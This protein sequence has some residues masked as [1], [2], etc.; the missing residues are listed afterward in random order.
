MDIIA[1]VNSD[2]TLSM[3]T[4]DMLYPDAVVRCGKD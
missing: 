1:V 4:M 3:D 2:A